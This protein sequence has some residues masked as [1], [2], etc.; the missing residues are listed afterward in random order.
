MSVLDIIRQELHQ[1]SNLHS[2]TLHYVTALPTGSDS[3]PSRPTNENHAHWVSWSDDIG[4]WVSA[5]GMDVSVC[6]TEAARELDPHHLTLGFT[7]V[8]TGICLNLQGQV[9]IHANAVTLQA[10][11]VSFVGYSG[12]GK[13]TLSAFCVSQGA[14]F[15]TDDVLVVDDQAHVLPGNARVKLYPDTSQAL[16]LDVTQPTDYK[17]FYHP[18]EH[19]GGYLQTGTIPLK[20]LYF[21]AESEDDKI[22]TVPIPPAQAV[23]DLITHGYDVSH[24]IRQ[25]PQLFDVYTQLVNTVPVLTLYYPRDLG[26]LPAVYDFLMQDIV[27]EK[28]QS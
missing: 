18:A 8:L 23:F 19:L 10:K 14:G 21:L 2:L 25:S 11:A 6:I 17:L 7:S 28:T 26:Q 4:A 24:F 22:Y 5:T 20:R 15:I 27:E 16:G 1:V 12:V 13:S 3:C 9:A